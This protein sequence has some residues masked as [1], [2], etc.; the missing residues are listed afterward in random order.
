[1]K[2][3]K[4][5]NLKLASQGKTTPLANFRVDPKDG[6][7]KQCQSWNDYIMYQIKGMSK[8][9]KP[10]ATYEVVK[11]M[12]KRHKDGLHIYVMDRL[13]R[14][15]DIVS[16]CKY[17]NNL[18]R[19]ILPSETQKEIVRRHKEQYEVRWKNYPN[20]KKFGYVALKY[21]ESVQRIVDAR[22][23]GGGGRRYG[24]YNNNGQQTQNTVPY[25]QEKGFMF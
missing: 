10:Y 18:R 24:S 16:A 4:G 8:S 15:N 20:G 25:D 6:N 3:I 13:Y 11:V 19:R 7:I 5:L 14:S 9:G 12:R 21:P 22:R 23:S 17:M 2:V 1:M